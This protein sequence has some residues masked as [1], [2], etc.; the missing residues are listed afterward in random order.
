VSGPLAIA[1]VTACLK[2]LLNDGLLNHDLSSIGS[3][4][5]TA[6][7]PDR[8][9]TGQAEPNQLN[10]FLY[11]VT[12]NQGWRNVGLPSRD[13]GGD[14]LTNPPLALDLH[15]MLTAYGSQD[16]NAEVLLGYSMQLLHETPMLSRQQ[17]RT[18]LAN[19][20]PVDGGLVPGIF[21]N[22]SAVDLADQIELLKITPN[23]LSSEDLS[24]LWTAMQA[25]YRPSMA[26]TVSV[27]LIQARTPAKMAPPV[28]MRGPGDRGFVALAGPIP[29]VTNARP[30]QSDLLPAL[31]LG[32]DILI[33][34]ANLAAGTITARLSDDDEHVS[35][36]LSARPGPTHDQLLVHL[37]SIAEE[38]NGM[39]NWAIGAYKL[40]LSVLLPNTEVW[41]T[42][43]TWIALAPTITVAPLNAAPGNINVTV[44]CTPRLRADQQTSVSLLFGSR[45]YPP[46]TIDTP[47]DTSLPTTLTFAVPAVAAGRYAVR[48]RVGDVD[49]IAAVVKHNPEHLE[50]DPLQTVVVA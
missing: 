8:I 14:R 7:P 9:T 1:A 46:A 36:T 28:L 13:A 45:Q 26:Y 32:D 34:G 16:L 2:D 30:A 23:F 22:L 38:G 17:I 35:R 6:T 42:N 15:Y 47:G 10:L 44:T 27:V 21:G 41:P 48:L 50:P 3:F 19:P 11:Q 31:K 39:S 20:S 49:S 4:S 43:S 18:V 24:K 12:P 40:G 25:R 29:Q 37:P 33:N 5:V